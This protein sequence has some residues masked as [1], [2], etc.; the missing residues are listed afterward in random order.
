MTRHRA[1]GSGD[2]ETEHHAGPHSRGSGAQPTRAPSAENPLRPLP[3]P[4][5][6]ALGQ[7]LRRTSVTGRRPHEGASESGEPLAEAR[8]T[9]PLAGEEILTL[10][11]NRDAARD[12]SPLAALR[13]DALQALDLSDT[14]VDDAGLVHLQGLTGLQA[15]DLSVTAIGD[16]GPA[17]LAALPSLRILN[18]AYTHVGDLGLAHLRRLIALEDLDLSDTDVGDEGLVHLQ[19]LRSL[20][21]LNLSGARS[22]W[23]PWLQRREASGTGLP[24]AQPG[25]ECA[26]AL[27]SEHWSSASRRGA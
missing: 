7:L 13:P 25:G 21:R 3:F 11:V 15:L 14:A 27:W 12:L 2:E 22:V 10:N 23:K 17:F 16:A 4:A 24:G 8:G 5:D 6:R 19:A 20:H 1:S 26:G 18:P 9:V